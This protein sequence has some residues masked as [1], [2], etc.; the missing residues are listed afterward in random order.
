M[1]SKI[2]GVQDA[3]D[4]LRSAAPERNAR[5]LRFQDRV[6]DL[7]GRIVGVN[8]HHLGAVDHDVGHFQLAEAKDILDVFRPPDLHFAVFRGDF[9]QPLD[10]G[11]AQ[12]LMM[13]AFGH[14]Q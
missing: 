6:D 10:L 14:M 13:R 5:V 8:R 12:N 4:V 1:R 9:D 7:S 2:L 3:N 11:L